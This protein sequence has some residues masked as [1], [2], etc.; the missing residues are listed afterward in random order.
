VSIACTGTLKDRIRLFPAASVAVTFTAVVPTGKVDPLGCE[1]VIVIAAAGVT[2]SVAVAG[3]YETSAPL[4]LVASTVTFAGTV[5]VGA[6]VS[7]GTEET[8]STA[9]ALVTLVP[10]PLRTVTT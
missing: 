5:N 3:E 1:Y 6:I 2:L 8:L 10:A 9:G 7:A 4:A